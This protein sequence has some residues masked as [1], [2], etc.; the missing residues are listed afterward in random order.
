MEKTHHR[1]WCKALGIVGHPVG[2]F[3][4]YNRENNPVQT[5]K[6]SLQR[7]L[8]AFFYYSFVS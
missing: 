7:K 1:S 6:K 3:L 5:A 2:P 4:R 8:K